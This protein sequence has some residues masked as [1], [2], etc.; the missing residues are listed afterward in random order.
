MPI[1]TVTISTVTISAVTIPDAQVDD[2]GVVITR[3]VKAPDNRRT[4]VDLIAYLDAHSHGGRQHVHGDGFCADYSM[5][6]ALN[7]LEH[8]SPQAPTIS[9]RQKVLSV[10]AAGVK[11]MEAKNQT[12]F[13]QNTLKGA[14]PSQ[15]LPKSDYVSNGV[16]V[17]DAKQYGGFNTHCAASAVLHVDVVSLD[18]SQSNH[19]LVPV[20]AAGKQSFMAVRAVLQR[21]EEPTSTPMIVIVFNGSRGVH[22]LPS[23]GGHFS[24]Y[25][26][27]P[28]RSYVLDSDGPT[29]RLS[30]SDVCAAAKPITNAV[31]VE[32]REEEQEASGAA[33]NDLSEHAMEIDGAAPTGDKKIKDAAASHDDSSKHAMEVDGAATTGD[34]K[35]KDAVAS[36]DDKS[37][38]TD[39]AKREASPD[40]IAA[41]LNGTDGTIELENLLFKLDGDIANDKSEREEGELFEKLKLEITRVRKQ[42]GNTSSD[43]MDDLYYV[44]ECDKDGNPFSNMVLYELSDASDRWAVGGTT[45]KSFQTMRI[46]PQ[47]STKAKVRPHHHRFLHDPCTCTCAMLRCAQPACSCKF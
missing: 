28:A 37:E 21:I 19:Q 9:D 35:T 14:I 33:P 46:D 32:A 8:R 42:Y 12:D 24:F 38:H 6:G 39:E 15:Y 41:E 11:W 7:L 36:H 40:S 30:S 45:Y 13:R 1:L 34:K 25:C 2:D 5:L 29:L 31:K 26:M 23:M 16:S 20:F 43:S 44:T 22:N 4:V 18:E 17:L 10:R 3:E 47:R 27:E